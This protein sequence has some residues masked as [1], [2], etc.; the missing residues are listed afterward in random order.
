M[1]IIA[2]AA[3]TFLGLSAAVNLCKNLSL[4]GSLTQDTPHLRIILFLPFIII[5]L[6]AVVYFLILKNDWLVCKISGSGEKLDPE[7]ET[8]WLTASLR[9]VAVIYGLILLA[10]SIPTILS[11]IISPMWIL[12]LINE[13][14]TFKAFPKS[15]TLEARQWLYFICN[16]LEALLAAYL[17]YGWPQFI[18]YQLGLRKSELSIDKKLNTGETKNE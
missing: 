4:I 5:L 9:M 7:S 16:L 15:F 3:L 12:P 2:K 10:S 11:I 6:I 18:R 14:L 17:L 8:L 1:Q 13:A